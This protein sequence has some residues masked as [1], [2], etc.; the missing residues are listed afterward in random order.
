MARRRRLE[1]L[2]L[3]ASLYLLFLYAPVLL[4]PLFSFNDSFY[5]A[6]PLRGF[7]LAWYR[8]MAGNAPL[9]EALQASL[10]VGVGVALAS[11]ALGV[12]AARAL[13]RYDLP[14]RAPITGF[15][16][17]PLVV[18]SL[19]LAL[20]LLVILRR[21]LDA[22][23]SLLTVAAGHV[24]LCVPYATLV[25]ISRLEGFDPSLEE[26]AADLGDSA[27][28]TFRRVTL[29]LAWPG[30]VSSL[31]LCF[32][33]SFDEYVLAAFLSG[34]QAT[35]PV[36]IFSQLRFPQRLPGV[37]ALGSCILAGS[38]LLVAFAEWI[39]RRGAGTAAAGWP[40]AR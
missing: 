12:L 10:A 2:S 38:I 1:G 7:T 35:L 32:S 40:A 23:L 3:Y 22:E 21:V 13:T 28:Q 33:A 15:I 16:M 36:F 19:V 27:W 26:A 37:L 24:M 25:M 31:L 6:F 9:I 17:L 20:A 39:R 8:E 30:I 11:T 14:G 34:N 29:P 18:P 4:L 5:V